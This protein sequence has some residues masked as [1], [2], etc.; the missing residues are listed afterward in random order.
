MNPAIQH[1][2]RQQRRSILGL[3]A[4]HRASGDWP[5]WEK[6]PLPGGTGG[7]GWNR[8]VRAAHRNGVF[9]VLERPVGGVVHLAVASLSGIRPTWHEM[10]RIK[11]EIVGEHATGV[12]VY[13][14]QSE[15]VDEADMFHIFIVPGGVPFSIY[16]GGR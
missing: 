4:K 7:G 5:P 6:I 8:E 11:N 14:P 13:P 10:Q 3:E 15:V 9:C 1:L 2:S 12:E 16:E